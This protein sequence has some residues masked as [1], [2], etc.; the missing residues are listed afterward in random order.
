[1][2][3][4]SAPSPAASPQHAYFILVMGVA[5]VA[6]SA[7]FVRLAQAEAA[8]SMVIAAGRLIVAA[9]LLTPAALRSPV[10]IAQMRSL[11]WRDRGLV[12]VSGVFLALHFATWVTSLE[13]TTVL[14]S[15]VL[16]TTTPIWVA[17]LEVFV[18]R[19][20]LSRPVI[21]GLVIAVTGGA[22]IGISG[23]NGAES[24]GNTLIGGLLSLAGAVTVAVY[25]IIGRKLRADLAL[26][27]YIWLVYGIAALLLLGAML[28]TGIPAG[29]YSIAAYGWILAMGLIPQLIGH[30]SLNYALA[31]LPATY[32]S[33]ATQLEPVLSAAA[34]MIIFAEIPAPMQFVGGLVI[35]CGVILATLGGTRPGAPRP[36]V[37]RR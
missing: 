7:I 31:Y 2:T 27:P 5:A 6:L 16:V 36:A 18:L 13:Y 33:L 19:A 14:I 26:T 12:V 37:N 21:I 30:S 11:S 32:V 25:L 28:V 1:M 8:P 34:A 35:M 29:G 22:V 23:A 4:T 20:R 9:L 15:V 24:G 10:Y 17:L 3:P